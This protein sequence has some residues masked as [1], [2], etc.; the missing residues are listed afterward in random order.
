[1]SGRSIFI[2]KNIPLAIFEA[3]NEESL[4]KIAG[5]LSGP[6]IA[7][8]TPWMPLDEAM[9]VLWKTPFS[10]LFFFLECQLKHRSTRTDPSPLFIRYLPDSARGRISRA[11]KNGN[12]MATGP[13]TFR[14]NV[15]LSLPEYR[16]PGRYPG[17][18]RG[19]SEVPHRIR[20]TDPR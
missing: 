17:P 11:V 12:V 1:M 2:R 4:V 13:R 18:G 9:N 8:I 7:H 20:R 15:Y 16:I 6:G 10:A 5:P 14:R 3:P 19:V